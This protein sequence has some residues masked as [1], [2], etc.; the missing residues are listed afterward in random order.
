MDELE[1]FLFDLCSKFYYNSISPLSL[2]ANT[3]T[4][5]NHQSDEHACI[6]SM[7][8]SECVAHYQAISPWFTLCLFNTQGS[9]LSIQLV[10]RTCTYQ[11]E[12]FRVCVRFGNFWFEVE[13]RE[14]KVF[15]KFPT[16][17]KVQYC[18][19]L[20]WSDALLFVCVYELISEWNLLC[21]CDTR[22]G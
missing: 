18:P 19:S 11:F 10:F 4:I 13:P 1:T 7:L 8:D 21:M 5:R 17:K 16:T 22:T 2:S 3:H 15:P 9:E 6:K 20:F 14:K 12:W